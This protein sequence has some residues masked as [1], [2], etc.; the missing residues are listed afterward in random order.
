MTAPDPIA[1]ATLSPADATSFCAA[2]T[3]AAGLPLTGLGAHQDRTLWL[4]WPKRLWRHSLRIADG[5][6]EAVGTV[7]QAV[8]AASGP[9]NPIDRK[10]ETETIRAL[11]SRGTIGVET[12]AAHSR[13][14]LTVKVADHG[15]PS[16]LHPGA[17]PEARIVWRATALH[18]TRP[19]PR[20]IA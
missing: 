2:Y 10:E 12:N 17:P 6:K 11:I 3:E 13:A 16:D 20:A 7:V 14:T 1:P 5:I 4:R 18:V 8:F 9:V 15:A 19:P